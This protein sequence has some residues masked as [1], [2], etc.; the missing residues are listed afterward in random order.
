MKPLH[1]PEHL[2]HSHYSKAENNFVLH[3]KKTVKHTVKSWISFKW[4]PPAKGNRWPR[5]QEC[6]VNT[7]WCV[8]QI[9]RAQELPS[10]HRQP[11][12]G[13]SPTHLRH[14]VNINQFLNVL[15]WLIPLTLL[16]AGEGESS[17][18]ASWQIHLPQ[19][20]MTK[21]EPV[22]RSFALLS[23]HCWSCL[24][25]Q[26]HTVITGSTQPASDQLEGNV[27]LLLDCIYNLLP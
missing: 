25:I 1:H 24:C 15:Y 17:Q 4:T 9:S 2:P 26:N 8:K 22:Q 19:H 7:G 18:A 3:L 13:L 12:P 14:Q 16:F 21:G 20:V 5:S 10:Q 23:G 6:P 27:S 11:S